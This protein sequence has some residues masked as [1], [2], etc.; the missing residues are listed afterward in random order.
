LFQAL[1]KVLLSLALGSNLLNDLRQVLLDLHDA[2]AIVR[3]LLSDELR[4]AVLAL[5]NPEAERLSDLFQG[6]LHFVNTHLVFHLKLG[7]F[8]HSV[9]FFTTCLDHFDSGLGLNFL[10]L[11]SKLIALLLM[12]S[13]DHLGHHLDILSPITAHLLQLRF[14]LT[15][16]LVTLPLGL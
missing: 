14:N 5:L 1:L 4:L 9:Y 10:D 12:N 7:P 16:E 8:S 15:L 6:V 13:A 11:P 2:L 3:V